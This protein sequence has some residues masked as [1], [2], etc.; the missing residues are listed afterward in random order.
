MVPQTR[1][2]MLKPWNHGKKTPCSQCFDFII[3]SHKNNV[4][5]NTNSSKLR[6]N[7]GTG[8]EL[9]V[10][11]NCSPVKEPI[12][13]SRLEGGRGSRRTGAHG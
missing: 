12:G 10:G 4:L 11:W 7:Q 9:V 2:Q 13:A 3:M 8:A 6:G 1:C 5:T